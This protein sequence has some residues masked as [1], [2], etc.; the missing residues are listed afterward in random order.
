MSLW[1][2]Y[3]RVTSLVF[4]S[5]RVFIVAFVCWIE[6][7]FGYWYCVTWNWLSVLFSYFR[8]SALQLTKRLSLK[9]LSQQPDIVLFTR[10]SQCEHICFTNCVDVSVNGLL[11]VGTFARWP[12]FNPERDLCS[13]GDSVTYQQ[14]L[15]RYPKLPVP[16]P[17][18]P[19]YSIPR[20]LL[21]FP[22]PFSLRLRF[23]FP[24]SGSH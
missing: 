17:I 23:S 24:Y 7:I 12:M 6:L 8:K 19:I 2:Y 9:R 14:F 16:C 13:N 18:P 3:K 10:D 4:L 5:Q 1:I 20:F 11:L 21:Y 15:Q 22:V